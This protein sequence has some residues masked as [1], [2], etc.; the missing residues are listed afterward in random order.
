MDLNR[1][2]PYIRVAWDSTIYPPVHIPERVL[3]DYELLYIKEG[4][5]EVIVD[6]IA[7]KGI[8]GDLFLFKPNQPHSIRTM[9]D[10]PL[11]QPHLHFDL[12]YQDDSPEVPISFKPYS[13]LNER[14]RQWIRPNDLRDMTPPLPSHIRLN[15]PE[16]IE[17]LMM[18]IIF[19]F[20]SKFPYYETTAKGLFIQLWM[21]LLREIHW[22]RSPH[23]HSNREQL[24]RVK[25]YLSHH[26]HEEATL[27][28]LAGLANMSKYYLCRLFKKAYG[29]TPIQYHLSV[30]LEKA[31]EMIRFTDL[32]LTRIA[33]ELGFQS[34]H[35]FSRAF[36]TREGV[37]PSAYRKTS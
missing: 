30:R 33:E 12:Y 20:D 17:Q 28:E 4:E 13:R 8:P 23:L 5:C 16:A 19:E 31:K 18:D 35:A 21:H 15:K 32:S 34:I 11:R 2:S 9:N 29:I 1:L 22:Q 37:S 24:D 3:F 6:G 27:E 25:N 10:R 14:E 36:R 7:Y 26:L